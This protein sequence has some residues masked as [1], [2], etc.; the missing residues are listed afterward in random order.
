MID[1]DGNF[2]GQVCHIEAAKEG[3][4]RFNPKQTNE[5]R[6]AFNNLM[7]MC[8]EHHIITNNV[9]EYTVERL[10]QMKASHEAK[11][12]DIVGVIR[13][14]IV[15]NTKLVTATY[16]SSLARYCEI[17]DL[18]EGVI[19]PSISEVARQFNEFADLLRRL[20]LS[21]RELLVILVERAEEY[22]YRG[23]RVLP[24]EIELVTGLKSVELREHL[25]ILKKHQLAQI[26]ICDDGDGIKVPY[27]YLYHE[28]RIN[29]WLEIKDFCDQ[30]AIPLEALI[31][32]LQFHLLD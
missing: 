15:D 7:L 5:D 2:V 30:M 3:G 23:M 26:I 6:R 21:T 18:N 4:E 29:I 16:P 17:F 22:D 14:S 31:K 9:D 20:P 32:N 19:I 25:N 27:I 12:T 8:Y 11:F 28:S 13:N 10:K 1:S 24:Y